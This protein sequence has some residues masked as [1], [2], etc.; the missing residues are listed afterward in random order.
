MTDAEKKTK[1]RLEIWSKQERLCALCGKPGGFS[2]MVL[3]HDHGT[4]KIRGVC[5]RMCNS[6]EGGIINALKRYGGGNQYMIAQ[7]VNYWVTHDPN[8]PY[9]PGHIWPETRKIR[10]L[11]K[12][13]KDGKKEGSTMR[14]STKTKKRKQIKD[15][16]LV[17]K[18][19]YYP[20][21][22]I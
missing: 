21:E 18:L 3:D 22:L 9:M 13:L 16:E 19:K 10:R 15:L 8:L 14:E 20:E 11:K 2:Q 7:V 4:G 6:L 1:L 5:H 12:D 17:I